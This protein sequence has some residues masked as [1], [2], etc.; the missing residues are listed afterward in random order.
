MAN[1]FTTA[2]LEN[3][4]EDVEWDGI[5]WKYQVMDGE[6]NLI[7]CVCDDLHTAHRIAKL[8]SGEPDP[9]EKA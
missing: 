8:L 7:M 1:R 6:Q 2:T 5:D 4:G 9:G 3:D